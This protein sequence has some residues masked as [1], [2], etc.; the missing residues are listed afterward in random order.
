[1]K[2]LYLAY[3]SPEFW[4]QAVAKFALAP[5]APAVGKSQRQ[6]VAKIGR[7]Q[8]QRASVRQAIADVP[9]GH[10]LLILNKIEPPEQRLYYVHSVSRFAWSRSVLL[11]QIKADAYRRSLAEGKAH[12][13]PAALPQHLVEQAEE[14]LKSSYN[15]EFLVLANRRWV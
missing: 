5:V 6:L 12:N 8:Q 2:R 7:S 3:S 15:L 9:W 13:F 14:A 4:R 10:H 11:N 1:M